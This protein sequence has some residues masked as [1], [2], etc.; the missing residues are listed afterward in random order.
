M[1]EYAAAV[2]EGLP[3]DDEAV[4]LARQA[5]AAGR[6]LMDVVGFSWAASAG[7]SSHDAGGPVDEH[8]V[9]TQ[10]VRDPR[11]GRLTAV[12]AVG[13]GPQSDSEKRKLYGDYGGWVNPDEL[14]DYLARAKRWRQEQLPLLW[15]KSAKAKEQKAAKAKA[16]G[17]KG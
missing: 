1:M 10:Y 16:K 12:G 17:G 15:S 7:R 11:S 13:G 3:P 14:D 5:A 8:G 4:L 6:T 2:L 9:P